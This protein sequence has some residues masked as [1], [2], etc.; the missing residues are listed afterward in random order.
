MSTAKHQVGVA[1]SVIP[2][3]DN[4]EIG[5]ALNREDTLSVPGHQCAQ[6]ILRCMG[7]ELP[8]VINPVNTPTSAD[9]TMTDTTP[10]L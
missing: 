9:T 3:F 1:S 5:Q 6:P 10:T 2:G 7:L 8:Q 4:I